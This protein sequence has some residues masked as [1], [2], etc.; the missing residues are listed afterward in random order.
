MSEYLISFLLLLHAIVGIFAHIAAI[1]LFVELL[2]T[3]INQ[4]RVISVSKKLSL[5]MVITWIVAGYWYIWLY[6]AEKAILLKDSWAF[7]HKFF[8]ETK[9]HIF[10]IALLISLFIPIVAIKNDLNKNSYAKKLMFT[11]LSIFIFVL[12]YVEG[13]GAIIG[14]GVKYS[15]YHKIQK[16]EKNDR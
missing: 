4:Q 6:P 7:A 10:F 11:L 2:S 15:L 8:M 5:L 14:Q 12:L 13:A 9:E 1:W 3:N 16:V